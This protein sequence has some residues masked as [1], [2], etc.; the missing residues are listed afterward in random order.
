[1]ANKSLTRRKYVIGGLFIA[2][3]VG[4][5]V[6][7]VLLILHSEYLDRF[8]QYGYLG[9]FLV[10]IVAGSP[11]PMLTPSM[12]LVVTFTFASIYNPVFVGLVSGLGLATGST[13]VYFSGRGGRQFFPELNISGLV[14][15]VYSSRIGQFLRKIKIQRMLDLARR[16]E[17]TAI[18]IL[19]MFPNPLFVPALVAAGATHT[20]F[21]KIFLAYWAGETVMSMVIVSLGYFGLH[22]LLRFLGIFGVQ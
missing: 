17:T 21:W 3:M 1:M 13:L 2:S 20:R 4:L 19:S 22:S 16:K 10:A 8:R 12:L 14:S 6:V 5:I 18:L 7:C 11:I 9:I 15:K